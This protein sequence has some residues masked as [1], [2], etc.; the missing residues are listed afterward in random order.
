MGE[1]PGVGRE[2]YPVRD[3]VADEAALHGGLA[4]DGECGAAGDLYE[5]GEPAVGGWAEDVRP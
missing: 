5:H 4:A 1:V 2:P 3:L